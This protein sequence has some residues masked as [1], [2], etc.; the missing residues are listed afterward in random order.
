MIDKIRCIELGKRYNREWIFRGIDTEFLKGTS[1]AV[2]GHNG[3][4]KSTFIQVLSGHMLQSEGT[5]IYESDGKPIEQEQVYKNISYSAPY[6]ELIEEFSLAEAVKFQSRFK[7]FLD[8]MSEEEVIAKSGLKKESGKMLKYFSSGM[9]Q[10]VK[11][12]LSILANTSIV[13]LDEPASNLDKSGIDWYRGLIEAYRRD[14]FVF[15]C[16]NQQPHEFDFCET[17]LKIEDYKKR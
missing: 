16:S 12:T 7:G 11:L 13:F 8:N 2:L 17:I 3:S 10:R 6:L 9:K 4:G 1:C 15:V 5:A 14:R